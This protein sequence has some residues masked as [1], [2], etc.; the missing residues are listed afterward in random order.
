[1]VILFL[2]FRSFV[3]FY[4]LTNNSVSLLFS[5]PRKGKDVTHQLP[6]TLEQLYNGS[7]KKLSV[8]KNDRCDKCS[9]SG[10][11]TPGVGPEKCMPCKGTG[12]VIR[13][14]QIHRGFVQ[15]VQ[16][17]CHDCGGRGSRI[18]EK[19][20]CKG[21]DGNRIMRK[22]DII[23]VH[24]DKGMPDQHKIM[25]NGKG[26][27]EPDIEPGDVV[28]VLEEQPHDVFQRVE[29]RDLAMDIT[30][31]ITEALCGFKRTIKTLDGRTLVMQ[32]LP[33]EVVHNGE[34]RC[35]L[36]EGMPIYKN[37]ME[38]GKL[39]I[40]FKVEFPKSLPQELATKLE[41]L[42]PARP[43]CMV[44]AD[45]EDVALSEFNPEYERSRNRHRPEAYDEEY[46][47]SPHP[48]NVQC[49]SH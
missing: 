2:T 5:G 22:R 31:N 25:F 17:Q 21:C 6:V 37:S 33:G 40:H 20:K 28:V 34:L 47:E 23:E 8:Q 43:V 42:L 39:L 36:N 32:T 16:S 49:A 19:D 30:L 26:H 45:A 46:D 48:S 9:G 10:S 11:K 12:V 24:I 4:R 27:W 38:K 18:P 14:E 44:P 3:C 35:I 29:N 7:T 13:I 1:M 15:Q 41:P